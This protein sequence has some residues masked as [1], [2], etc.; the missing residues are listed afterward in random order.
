[1]DLPVSK[2]RVGKKQIVCFI[3]PEASER[4]YDCCLQAGWTRQELLARAINLGLMEL[5]EP[6]RLDYQSKRVFRIPGRKRSI[7]ENN[8]GRTG[9]MAIA[10][11]YPISQVNR[12]AEVL[13]KNNMNI[14]EMASYGLEMLTYNMLERDNE[15]N[16][17]EI[18]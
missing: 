10:G 12:I 4:Y 5:N 14:Q 16:E 2:S 6:C 1:M 9:K 13:A 11:W 8:Y 3:K 18:A 7:R 17:V 15:N